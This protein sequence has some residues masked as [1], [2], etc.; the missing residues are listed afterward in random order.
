MT[1]EYVI[2]QGGRVQ[3]HTLGGDDAEPTAVAWAADRV[4][5]VGADDL[6]RSISRGDSTFVD[7]D[8]CV[9]TALP[10]DLAS[11]DTLVREVSLSGVLDPDL[12]G[13]F[14]D[15][16]LL[17]PDSAL[18]PG[19]PAELAFWDVGPAP[20]GRTHLVA[21]VRGGAFTEGDEHYG[22]FSPAGASMPQSGAHDPH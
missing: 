8:G 2:A 1:H 22:P 5:A 15:A 16:G 14:I 11:A 20:A 19:S 10:S 18:E 4:L 13:L 17:D 12:G 7:L 3:P 9:V 6:V 21:V